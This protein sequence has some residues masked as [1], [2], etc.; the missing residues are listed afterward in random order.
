VKVTV[1]NEPQRAQRAQRKERNKEFHKPFMAAMVH[2]S[3]S[4]S[5]TRLS[6]SLPFLPSRPLRPL[7]FV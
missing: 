5:T 4:L 6:I 1:F 2:S 7:R 3:Y